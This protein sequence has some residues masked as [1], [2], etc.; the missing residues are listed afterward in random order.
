MTQTQIEKRIIR[1]S[2]IA[3]KEFKTHPARQPL[4]G[5]WLNNEG[6]QCICIGAWA[7]RY[8]KPTEGTINAPAGDRIDLDKVFPTAVDEA[9]GF[10]IDLKRLKAKYDEV[11]K[12]MKCNL[13]SEICGARFNVKLMLDVFTT[14]DGAT[15][16]VFDSKYGEMLYAYGYN[17]EALLLP[18]RFSENLP[19]IHKKEVQK[20]T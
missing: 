19:V 7:V 10:R 3:N 1:L 11:R 2:K 13:V 6:H 15:Y 8:L 9:K 14:I 17:G 12:V 20:C 5:A 4:A 16:F 18:L